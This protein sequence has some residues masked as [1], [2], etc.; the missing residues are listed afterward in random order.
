[1]LSF[2]AI[3]GLLLAFYIVER[4]LSLR[5]NIQIAEK[6]QLPYIV[7]PLYTGTPLWYFCYS[8]I[9]PSFKALPERWTSP[10]LE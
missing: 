10:W 5:R 6:T 8:W 1:M 2:L 4:C 7:V 9:L 3:V